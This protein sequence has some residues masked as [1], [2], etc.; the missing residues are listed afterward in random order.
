MC[1]QRSSG[2]KE[3]KKE[4]QEKRQQQEQEQKQHEAKKR[5]CYNTRMM[6]SERISKRLSL[7]EEQSV[8]SMWKLQRY[9]A[10]RE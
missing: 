9:G 4:E 1:L 3:C 8:P 10:D 5:Q 6:P 7:W 2:Q